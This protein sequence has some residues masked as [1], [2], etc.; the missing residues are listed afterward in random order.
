LR[1]L[2]AYIDSRK[3]NDE[4]HWTCLRDETVD[5]L[6]EAM[7]EFARHDD[8][9]HGKAL[10]FVF[11]VL[12]AQNSRFT[13][14]TAQGREDSILNDAFFWAAQHGCLN[15]LKLIESKHEKL[16]VNHLAHAMGP[17]R[18]TPFYTAAGSG[19]NSIVEY[20]FTKH[21]EQ[22]NIHLSNGIFANGPTTMWITV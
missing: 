13:T 15:M 12:L 4:Y 8:E 3:E 10:V 11:D 6:V 20:L 2:F 5:S 22:L 21:G 1:T 17:R 16:N 7:W 14:P 9:E 19:H 18:T